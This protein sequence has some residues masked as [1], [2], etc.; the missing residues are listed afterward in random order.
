M[1]LPEPGLGSHPSV[2]T[3]PAEENHETTA[4]AKKASA[5]YLEKHKKDQ[6]SCSLLLVVMIAGPQQ[7]TGVCGLTE[8]WRPVHGF[9]Q[10]RVIGQGEE[11]MARLWATE[12]GW[13]RAVCEPHSPKVEVLDITMGPTL[14]CGA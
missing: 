14:V 10:H 6:L 2:Y 1:R 11:P 9:L 13:W 7:L 3:F 4:A 8:L 12:L 5:V